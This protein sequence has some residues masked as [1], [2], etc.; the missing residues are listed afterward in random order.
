MTSVSAGH[1]I[2]TSTQPVGSMWPQQGSNPGPLHQESR[3]TIA[4]VSL[5][6]QFCRTRQKSLVDNQSWRTQNCISPIDLYHHT[7]S[8]QPSNV[9]NDYYNIHPK[10]MD[11]AESKPD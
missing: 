4:L 3:D 7:L 8:T 1:I 11:L 10:S 5:N 6:A 9:Q 2:L